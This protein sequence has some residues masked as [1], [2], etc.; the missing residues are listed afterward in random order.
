M[1]ILQ[2]CMR[3]LKRFDGHILNYIGDSIMVVFGA[4]EKLKNHE[5]RAVECSLKMNNQLKELNIKWD[6]NKLSRYWKNHGIDSI[7]MRTGIP[8]WKRNCW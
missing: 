5:N 6:E 4:P 3:L 2:K 1:N 8:Y 7:K